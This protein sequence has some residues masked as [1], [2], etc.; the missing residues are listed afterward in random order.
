MLDYFKLYETCLS[1]IQKDSPGQTADFIDSMNK[2]DF[3]L[4][5]LKNGT[6]S[7]L[8]IHATFETLDNLIEDGLIKAN[9]A[10]TKDGHIYIF[11]GLTTIGHQYLLSLKNDTFLSKLKNELKDQGVPTTPSNITKF[12]ARLFL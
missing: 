11:S 6:S 5:E 12:I 2:Q 1:V 10:S 8:L 4:S 7:E 3:V 9:K